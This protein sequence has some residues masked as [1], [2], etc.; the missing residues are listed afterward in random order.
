MFSSPIVKNARSL[1]VAIAITLATNYA[2]SLA[3]E[4]E[5]GTS[6]PEKPPYPKK[7]SVLEDRSTPEKPPYPKRSTPEKPPYPK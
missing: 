1:V 2:I 6:T 3:V 4:V 7:V 5:R